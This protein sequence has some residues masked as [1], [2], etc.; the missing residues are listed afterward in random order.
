[1]A[2]ILLL[3]TIGI[4]EAYKQR[5]GTPMSTAQSILTDGGELVFPKLL[6]GSS[7]DAWVITDNLLDAFF[8]NRLV[9]PE[10]AVWSNKRMQGG[11]LPPEILISIVQK[12]QPEQIL[13]RRFDQAPAFLDYLDLTYKRIPLAQEGANSDGTRYYVRQ[14][15]KEFAIDPSNEGIPVDPAARR[16]STAASN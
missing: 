13:L 7:T 16:Y 8:A 6:Q 11:Y 2:C 3:S 4:W 9:P 14:R 12:R 1:M 10:L 15:Q 5:L